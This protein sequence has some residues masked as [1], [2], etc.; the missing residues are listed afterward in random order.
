MSFFT[1]VG[2]LLVLLLLAYRKASLLQSTVIWAVVALAALTISLALI[3]FIICGRASVELRQC[4][5]LQ[6]WVVVQ[7]DG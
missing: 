3:Q 4:N 2:L 5:Q 6:V 7:A 1:C